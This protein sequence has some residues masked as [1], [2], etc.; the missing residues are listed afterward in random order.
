MGV[1]NCL[2]GNNMSGQ[3]DIPPEIGEQPE[4][5]PL[6]APGAAA[7]GAGPSP[8]EEMETEPPHN[9]PIPI[10]NDGEACGP[11]EVSR[12][13]FQ[14]L[15]PAF[16]EAGAHGSYSP[17]PEE[18]MPFEIEQPSSEGFWPTLEQPGFP[19][20]AH[21]GLEAF[22]PAL[23]EPGAF[24]G[25]RPGLGG[26]SP[27]PEEAMPFE[28]DQPAQRGCSQPFLQ[29]PDLAPGGPGAAGVPGAPPEEPQ[30][31]RPAKAGSRGGYS[32]PPEETM[33]FEL[34][35]E[36]FG[37]DSPPPG[38]SRVI[39]QVDGSGQFAAVAASSAVRL[40]PAANAPPLWVPGAIGSPSREAVRPS[41]FTGT[42]PR[43]EISGPPLEIGSAPAGVDDTLINM[44]SPPIALDGPPIKASGAPDKRERAERPP[45]EEEAAEM[46]G[47]TAAEA[48][49]GGKV[50]SPGYGSP[51]AGA[52]SADTAARAAP[53][54]PADPDSGAAPEDPD[55]GEAPAD[56]DSGAFSADPDSGAAPADPDSG[57][58][59]GASA[60]PDSGAAPDAPADPDSGAA[61]DA[62]ADPDSGAA[63][64]APADPDAGA[65]PEAP[66]APAAPETRAAHVAPAAP[67]AGAPTAPAASAT[68]AARVP[69]AA[70][71]APASGARRKVHLRP[72]SPEIQVAD[73]PTPRPTRASAWR[74]KSESSRGHR[75]YYDE[76]AASS[77]EDS[78]G[79]ES[80]DGTFRC[81][82]WFQHRR[83]RH[84]RKPQRNLLRNFLIQAFA[85]CFGRSESPQPKASHSPKVK[86]VPLAEKRRQ[87]R[88]EALEKRAQKRAEKKRSKLI[89]KQL[90][91]E[92]MG[93][94]CTHRLLLLGAGESGKSTIVKQ[95][96]ILHVNGFNGEGG[97]E[98]PQAARSNSDGE[99]ATKVQ[100]IKNNL[101]E[102][103]E[104]IVAAMSNLVPP[105]ELANPE[106]QFRVDYILSVMNVPDFDFPPEFYEHAK[107]LWEDEGV[108]ACYER[109]N[110]Y[111]LIDCAQYFLDKIDVIKQAD[112]VPSDQD[113]LRCRVL[114]S[115]IFETKFQVDKVNFHMFDVGG[116]RDERR[117]WIQCFNDV[118]AIIFV[119][120]SSSYNMVIR[121]DNQTNR[122]QEALN[123]FKSI[124]NNRWLRTIS[125]ILFLNKQ[126]LLAEKVLAGKSKIEDYFPE[127][128]RYTTPEDA[129]PEPG[130]D[131]RVTRAKYF[132]R[133]EFLRISTASGDG[134]HYCYPHF[135]CAVD[136]ENIRR[137]FNDCRDIIQRMHLRQYEL[138]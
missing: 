96:R 11:P 57:A 48:A 78:S 104:T 130:E 98:D 16:G 19:S 117:K 129:T 14:V 112:Y 30:A 67:D 62:P 124:W 23:M 21:A 75:G 136:T 125:V 17:P 131:P 44:G 128:A 40:T 122:L 55:S 35:G 109:S 66:A 10:E 90:Q 79:D 59:P 61:P 108:R 138:L 64:D 133:D 1:R 27:P 81:V 88:K 73:P 20:G 3:R 31:L 8:A 116:Q 25:A 121:E 70:S 39:A 12:P 113:L 132:I 118:T 18:A 80:D 52:A 56:P 45:V 36:G 120:A 95:M 47:G 105:V 114:T 53:A 93:Y 82:R 89:D 7:P 111:Q 83:N 41:N 68:Q 137:V 69:R 103:I 22:G 49:E 101:K 106:N 76:G 37:D 127:F 26:Y 126:D 38:L 107:A 58:A 102:A 87:M 92:K 86:K 99:K 123:L 6:E 60:D 72:P 43:M 5:P 9:E 77:D 28:F 91:D 2:D 65:A 84:R 94:M 97:E 33:P 42:S 63:P 24:S 34:D 71:A 51:A 54:A 4:Q 115:G 29:V 85:G 119:V 110:E 134:R 32:P 13:N 50:P 74:G 100:D 15:N 46:E 135:T